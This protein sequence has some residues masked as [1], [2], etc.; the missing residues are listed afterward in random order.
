MKKIVLSDVL[1]PFVLIS[2]SQTVVQPP[3]SKSETEGTSAGVKNGDHVFNILP[4]KEF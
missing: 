3:T 2:T 4:G 1:I